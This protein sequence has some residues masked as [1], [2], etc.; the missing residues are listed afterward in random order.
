MNQ[1][2]RDLKKRRFLLATTSVLGAVGIAGIS[3]PFIHS[4]NPSARART[5]GAPVEVD[6]SK[7][8]PGQQI[9]IDWRRKPVW[10]LRRTPEMLNRLEEPEL[11]NRLVD[12]NSKVETQ[13]PP[14]ASNMHRSIKHEYLVVIGICTHLGCVP[15]FR[16]EPAAPDLGSDW[17][18]GYFCPCHGSRF[19]LAGRVFKHVPAP[20]NLVIP[21]YRYLSDSVIEV[22]V[23]PGG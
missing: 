15:N 8:E 11:L 22:G 9:T 10:I 19:D 18:G 4:M 13:Q 2:P 12:P 14:Y 6:I 7:L 1:P 5:A 20:T 21:P 23:D 3:V 16:P 17:P